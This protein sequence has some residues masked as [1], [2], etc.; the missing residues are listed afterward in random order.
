VSP[1]DSDTSKGKGR[2]AGV[3]SMGM[4]QRLLLAPGDEETISD[5]IV[6]EDEPVSV[7]RR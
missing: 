3:E 2:V 6:E 7:P 5:Y 4:P 1:D